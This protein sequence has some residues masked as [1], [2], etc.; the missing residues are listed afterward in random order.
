LLFSSPELSASD[1][2]LSD[3]E[4]VPFLLLLLDFF[5]LSFVGDFFAF[6]S[7]LSSF[8]F[9]LLSDALSS[10]DLYYCDDALYND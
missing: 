6:L 1:E 5:F 2:L 10:I 4:E 8:D 3:D 9:P 7:P